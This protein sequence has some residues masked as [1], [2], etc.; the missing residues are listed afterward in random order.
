MVHS[1]VMRRAPAEIPEWTLS[2]MGH[3]MAIRRYFD[4]YFLAWQ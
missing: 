2:L 4:P 1:T 3:G